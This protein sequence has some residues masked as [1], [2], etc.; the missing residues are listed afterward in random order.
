MYTDFDR[1]ADFF[2]G[3]ANTLYKVKA[4]E[5]VTISNA[6]ELAR[7]FSEAADFI[8]ETLNS[9]DIADPCTDCEY[10]CGRTLELDSNGEIHDSCENCLYDPVNRDNDEIETRI[11]VIRREALNEFNDSFVVHEHKYTVERS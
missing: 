5:T 7:W 9:A 11:E 8:V 1:M 10:G 2:R 3:A 6:H 4:D